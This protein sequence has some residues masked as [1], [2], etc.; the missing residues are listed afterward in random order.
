[1]RR[2][3]VSVCAWTSDECFVEGLAMGCET[4]AQD[5]GLS[6]IR[7]GLEP[8][9]NPKSKSDSHGESNSN[10]HSHDNSKSKSNSSSVAGWM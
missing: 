5:P 6:W 8:G 1:M 3:S 4:L 9:P 7:S 2:V 10:S